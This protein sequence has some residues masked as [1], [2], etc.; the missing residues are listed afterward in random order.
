M[1]HYSTFLHMWYIMVWGFYGLNLNLMPGCMVGTRGTRKSCIIAAIVCLRQQCKRRPHSP[2]WTLLWSPPS[3]SP[4]LAAS[5][6]ELNTPTFRTRQFL[7]D[8]FSTLPSQS[9]TIQDYGPFAHG[10]RSGEL[11]N[12]ALPD[13]RNYGP[14]QPQPQALQCSAGA[15]M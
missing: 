1:V 8:L 11:R 4:F 5:A 10:A 3:L 6:L 9:F 15:E 14:R 12:N 2:E 7:S 13:P